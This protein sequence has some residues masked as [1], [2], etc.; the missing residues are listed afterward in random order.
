MTNKVYLYKIVINL[1]TSCRSWGHR[2]VLDHLQITSSVL[3][4]KGFNISL[5]DYFNENEGII[6]RYFPNKPKVGCFIPNQ[7]GSLK[8]FS[9]FPNKPK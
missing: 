9:E 5:W 8:P 2:L 1:R 3:N 4:K 7:G 6:N